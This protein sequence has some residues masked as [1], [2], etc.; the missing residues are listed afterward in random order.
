MA[1]KDEIQLFLQDFKIKLDVWGLLFQ[2]RL[3]KKNF[4]TMTDLEINVPDVKKEL[5]N[6]EVSNYVE[7]PLVDKL[8]NGSP[9]WVFGR[10]VLK[11]EIYIKIT[12]GR[13]NDKVICISFHFPDHKMSYC[14][15]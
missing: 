9:M 2:N 8:Y 7:G 13:P 12:M 15:K 6:L 14:Y 11:H 5:K 1:P 3:N 4:R 10:V